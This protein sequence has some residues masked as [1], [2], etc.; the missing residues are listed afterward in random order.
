M[1]ADIPQIPFGAVY[2]RKSNPPREDWEQDYRTAAEDRLNAFW[3]WFLWSAIERAPGV[4]DWDDYDRQF[5]L[6]EKHGL[7]T[8]IAELN[9]AGPDWAVRR[10]PHARQIR[11]D[12]RTVDSMVS[13]SAAIG[14]FA[15]NGAGAGTLTFN[16]GDVRE[17]A[18]GLLTQP[19]LR[20]KYH[21]A[22]LGYYVWNECNYSPIVDFSEP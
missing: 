9:H 12:G 8:M 6:A 1:T 7:K 14:G 22:L 20:Y 3:H 15:R 16:S 19:A 18:A 4:F 11:F 5:D 13:P 21:P 10:F 2:F 17:A